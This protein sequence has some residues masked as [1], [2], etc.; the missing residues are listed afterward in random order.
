MRL[1]LIAVSITL[2]CS[3]LIDFC[4]W[5]DIRR[6]CRSMHLSGRRRCISAYWVSTV[7]CWG[8]LLTVVFMPK[9]GE[10]S[11]I[12]L[13]WM[14]YAYIS[15]YIPKLIYVLFSL[16]GR[17]PSLWHGKSIKLGKYVGLPIT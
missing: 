16:I 17:I 14:L 1:P 3:L 7:L 9:R 11:I 8:L 15:V 4:I 6:G 10:S 5:H 2:I 13:M 12:P